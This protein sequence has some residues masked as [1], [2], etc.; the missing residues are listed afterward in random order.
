MPDPYAIFDSNYARMFA[1]RQPRTQDLLPQINPADEKSTVGWMMEQGL[2]GLGYLGS[3]LDKTF[4]GRGIRGALGGHPEELASILPFSD[5]LGITDPRNEV[6]GR[7]LLAN[8]GL[9]TQRQP[10]EPFN[11]QDDLLGM[12]AEMA[13]DPST[14]LSLGL[15]GAGKAAAKTR[16]LAGGFGAQM[17]AGQRG[18]T[19]NLPLLGGNLELLSG[20]NVLDAASGL[21]SAA[22]IPTRGLD[23]VANAIGGV[24]PLAGAQRRLYENLGEPIGRSLNRWF[25]PPVKSAGS[26][27]GQ[28]LGRY[29]TGIEN[30]LEYQRGGNYAQNLLDVQDIAGKGADPTRVENILRSLQAKIEDADPGLL[31]PERK[32]QATKDAAQAIS[33]YHLPGDPL[34]SENAKNLRDW[35]AGTDILNP[36]NET[37]YGNVVKPADKAWIEGKLANGLPIPTDTGN[38]QLLHGA[39]DLINSGQVPGYD[40]IAN[41]WNFSHTPEQIKAD[42]SVLAAELAKDP[43]LSGIPGSDQFL[44]D[45]IKDPTTG[46][47]SLAHPQFGAAA[48]QAVQKLPKI[49]YGGE[50]SRAIDGAV[51]KFEAPKGAQGYLKWA[52]KNLDPDEL[53]KFD[54]LVD[55]TKERFLQFHELAK[56]LGVRT[57]EL[58]DSFIDYNFRQMTQFPKGDPRAKAV[59]VKAYARDLKASTEAYFARES[60]FKNVPQGTS[61]LNEW[62]VDPRLSG[63]KRT[64]QDDEVEKLL[65]EQITGMEFPAKGNPAW[66]QAKSLSNWLKELPEHHA[67]TESKT[68]WIVAKHDDPAIVGR[69]DVSGSIELRI[70]IPEGKTAE[71]IAKEHSLA[72]GWVE[73]RQRPTVPFFK[74][75]LPQLLLQREKGMNAVET[76]ARTAYEAA[77]RYSQPVKEL[78]TAGKEAM[79]LKDFA[80]KMNLM[81]AD[82]R[83]SIFAQK[84]LGKEHMAKLDAA[85]KVTL[86]DIKHL[87]LDQKTADDLFNFNKAFQTP[88]VMKPVLDFYDKMSD[89]MKT[90]LTRPFLSFHTRNFASNLFNTWRSAGV[91]GLNPVTGKGVLDF[92]RGGG[93]NLVQGVSKEELWKELVAGRIAFRPNSSMEADFLGKAG[94]VVQQGARMPEATGRTLLGDVGARIKQ[95]GAEI[96]ANPKEALNPLN[97]KNSLI[98]LMSEG[99]QHIEDFGRVNHY[100]TLRKQGWAPEAASNEVLKYQIDYSKVLTDTERAVFRRLFPWLSFSKGTLP[101]V[102]EDLVSQPGKITGTVRA[103][104]GGRP[105]G[106]FVPTYIGEGAALP[107]GQNEDGTQRYLSSFGLPIEDESIKLLGSLLKGDLGRAGEIGLG[108]TFPWVKSP[109]ELIFNKQLY[110]GR[111]LEDL[112]PYQFADLGGL[113]NEKQARVLTEIAANTPAS[114][115]LSTINKLTDERKSPMDQLLALGTGAKLTDVDVERAFNA[116]ATKQLGEQLIGQPGVRRHESVYV[117]TDKIPMLSPEDQLKY[118]LLLDYEEKMRKAAEQRQKAAGLAR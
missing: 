7:D 75:D 42:K 36:T 78:E 59:G 72:P 49:P 85:E 55:K 109:L 19:A 83:G 112:K 15:T 32:A 4:G 45:W 18:L 86:D 24:T 8:A 90:Y 74:A 11:W 22:T 91:E 41:A 44:K 1:A 95:A 115:T 38:V 12:A 70:K 37:L 5:T 33:E 102:L 51:Q 76:A 64:L 93:D 97:T 82:D 71:D 54:G 73:E 30:S 20:S 66:D 116:A 65:R 88:A 108:A 100:V 62:S 60:D 21:R 35:Q 103:T 17:R 43:T 69:P 92:L 77:G 89:I 106:E 10:D 113:L 3:V 50:I 79:N 28:E 81:G 57:S 34:Y 2:G 39:R 23:Y 27:Q 99:G 87:G 101:V 52:E 63:E 110:S 9:A 68:G 25:A 67:G 84:V 94:E 46:L 104:T 96:K 114:R 16:S 13:L 6:S 105:Q 26:A 31:L 118:R 56:S 117:P 14:Y 107:L 80:Q 29:A 48:Q 53:V 58:K 98:D 61:T 40:P 111:P 47:S